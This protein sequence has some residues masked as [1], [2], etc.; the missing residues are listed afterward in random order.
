ME[1]GQRDPVSSF[2]QHLRAIE[3]GLALIERTRS[4][5]DRRVMLGYVFK[6]LAALRD[7][8]SAA[9][10]HLG[11]KYAAMEAKALAWRARSGAPVAPDEDPGKTTCRRR[12]RRMLMSR[13]MDG[14]AI[15][16]L[17][18][19]RLRL[20]S[21]RKSDVDDYAAA[22]CDKCLQVS[23]PSIVPDDFLKRARPDL[24]SL[25][26]PQIEF[27]KRTKTPPKDSVEFGVSFG[28]T[29]FYRM[30]N[31]PTLLRFKALARHF[32]VCWDCT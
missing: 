4:R 2:E 8:V 17:E 19:E 6:D 26:H 14:F 3:R 9:P 31:D 29:Y 20:R 18:T 21:F 12:R 30:E 16:T 24:I 1:D 15:P 10:H 27:T 22:E 25:S 28:S 5:D 13:S 11:E 23:N 7:Q 32:K